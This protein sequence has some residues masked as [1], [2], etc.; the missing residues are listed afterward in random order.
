MRKVDNLNISAVIVAAGRGTRMNMDMNKQYIKVSGIP[1]LARTI[2]V[3]EECSFVNDIILVVNAQDMI[4]C[5]QNIVSHY[6]F[7]KIRS[8]VNGG[9][10]R[11]ESVFNG[12]KE[13]HQPCDIVMIHDGAR[14]F[15]EEKYIMDSIDAACEFGAACVAVPV[16]DTVKVCDQEG[17][18]KET[19]DRKTLWS[20]QT[21]Q[22]FEYNLIMNA[23][24]KAWEEGFLGTD[25][26]VLIERS[27]HKMKI[28][29]GDY[30]NIKI[31]TKEDLAL[32]EIIA[33]Q[34]DLE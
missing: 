21:P 18:V 33:N 26:A 10:E 16:K 13:I 27:G 6:D 12:L 29:T 14:P 23:H 32:A 25:D 2:K 17:F 19:P 20:I 7:S 15:V 8:L 30:S 9:S 5:K 34:K 24:R 3:F 22:T 1:V 11:Q 28:V 31:T 4:Y